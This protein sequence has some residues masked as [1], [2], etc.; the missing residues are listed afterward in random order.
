MCRHTVE[1][2][3]Y[4]TKNMNVFLQSKQPCRQPSVEICGQRAGQ[5]ATPIKH[6]VP[7]KAVGFATFLK[8]VSVRRIRVLESLFIL[9]WS[10][11][12]IIGHHNRWGCRAVPFCSSDEG[13]CESVSLIICRD[14]YLY[15]LFNKASHLRTNSYLQWCPRNSGLTA[16]FRGRTSD[17][18]LVSSGISFNNLPV[19]G[20][21]L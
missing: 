11:I 5:R 9:N 10:T 13:A 18:Y 4:F 14:R 12:S 3:R 8:C 6:M 16:L 17:F 19:T 1:Y 2:N 7:M 21:T 15:F 20:P